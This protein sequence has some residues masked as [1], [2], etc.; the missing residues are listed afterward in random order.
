MYVRNRKNHQKDLMLRK[1]CGKSSKAHL[2]LCI[3]RERTEI[4]KMNV[5]TGERNNVS[6]NFQW[7]TVETRTNSVV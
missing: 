3:S 5:A 1:Q 7:Q 6:T 4:V 2:D